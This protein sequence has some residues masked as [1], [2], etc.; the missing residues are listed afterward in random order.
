MNDIVK[1]KYAGRSYE[2]PG[3]WVAGYC[4]DGRT[5]FDAIKWWHYQA[6]LER[7]WRAHR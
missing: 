3:I 2:I 1:V 7:L 5:V 6:E 4:R